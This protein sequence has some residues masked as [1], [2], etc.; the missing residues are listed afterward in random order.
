MT[1]PMIVLFLLVAACETTPRASS[2]PAA[3]PGAAPSMPVPV[4][5]TIDVLEPPAPAFE[6]I[7][8]D[9]AEGAQTGATPTGVREI[10]PHGGM[11][12]CL[13]MY[14]ACSP[15]PANPAIRRCTSAPLLL[16]CGQTGTIPHGETLFCRCP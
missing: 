6:E 8:L 9:V 1:R 4:I 7:D 14:S 11:S 10:H 12:D 2:S 16:A 3:R 15:D 5:D 13:E